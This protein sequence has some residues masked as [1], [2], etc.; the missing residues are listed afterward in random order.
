MWLP[1]KSLERETELV[2]GSYDALVNFKPHPHPQAS[3]HPK[4]GLTLT[5]VP[6][7]GAVDI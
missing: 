7:L 4:G 3:P 6:T 5:F 2:G 1:P